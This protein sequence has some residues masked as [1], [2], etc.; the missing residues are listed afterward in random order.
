MVERSRKKVA[1]KDPGGSKVVGSKPKL[2]LDAVAD[3]H[4]PDDGRRA[5]L[6]G[7]DAEPD[8][9]P[10]E[11]A[12]AGNEDDA[13]AA[14]EPPDLGEI[15]DADE[16]ETNDH[17]IRSERVDP[18][19]WERA[20]Y[21]PFPGGNAIGDAGRQGEVIASSGP[22][23]VGVADTELDFLTLAPFE[24]RACA[25]RGLSHRHAGTP[26]QDSFAI[27]TSD[28]WLVLAVA[29]GVSQGHWSHVAAETASRAAC[30]LV[31][32]QA[33]R[34]ELIDWSVISR[35]V[36]MRVLEEAEYRRLISQPESSEEADGLLDRLERCRSIMSTTLVVAL[37]SRHIA[38]AG[39]FPVELAVLAGDSGVYVMD[40]FGTR[41]AVG[42][43]ADDGSPIT[44]GAVRPLPGAVE[45]DVVAF[46]AHA[47]QAVVL[48]SDGLGDPIGDGG[49]EVGQALA[50]RWAAPPTIDQFLVDVNFLRRSFDDDRTAVAVW[51]LPE[52]AI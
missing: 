51:M 8:A 23:T 12:L 4:P 52:R 40:E 36:S 22:L 18:A 27:A 20:A 19:R 32:D 6:G 26:R 16:A 34:G 46:S 44:S 25:T 41:L 28:D 38:D 13:P 30:K 50:R 35:R 39:T 15:V 42:G 49:G 33:D 10:L 21:P 43:K 47:G 11:D 48:V 45:P 24:V 14:W 7:T 1:T 2:L 31:L 29:D 3:G 17:D 5:L 37:V 9:H